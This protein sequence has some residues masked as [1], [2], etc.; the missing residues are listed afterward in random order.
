MQEQL[1]LQ[2]VP[3]LGVRPVHPLQAAEGLQKLSLS[4]LILL[5]AANYTVVGLLWYFAYFV[6][7]YIGILAFLLAI[8]IFL[9][10]KKEAFWFCVFFIII[11][12]PGFFFYNT[13]PL[14]SLGEHMSFD[15]RDLFAMAF[16]AKG[17]FKRAS[18]PSAL[19]NPVLALL[20]YVAF[21]FLLSW[22][23]LPFALGPALNFLRPYFY[24]TLIL[25]FPLVFKDPHEITRILYLIMSWTFFV[26]ATQ[27]YCWKT[28]G[29]L[30]NHFLPGSRVA[31][32]FLADLSVRPIPG[33]H[34]ILIFSYML[35]LALLMGEKREIPRAF[36]WV[37]LGQC[38]FSVLLSG[39]RSW[40]FLLTFV[41]LTAALKGAR[42]VR[43]L[44]AFCL[45][46]LLAVWGMGGFGSTSFG[47]FGVALKRVG[48]LK[49]GAEGDFR[50]IDTA[51]E[52]LTARDKLLVTIAE[53]PVFGWGFSTMGIESYNNDL[54]FD[55]TLLLFGVVGFFFFVTFQV[56][57]ILMLLESRK[58]ALQSSAKG[59]G[60][61]FWGLIAGWSGLLLGYLTTQ[62]LFTWYASAISAM[63]LFVAVAEHFGRQP[64]QT[65]IPALPLQKRQPAREATP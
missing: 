18:P 31:A 14:L 10:S 30:V 35:S 64:Q 24:Y 53:E 55:N 23:T 21:S 11:Q 41:L 49:Q 58:A 44:A 26:F 50:K 15:P 9:A 16:L 52:R 54:G 36:L 12:S 59:T 51:A 46:G 22:M 48:E 32:F 8:G 25:A 45:I 38:F 60:A 40:S 7:S 6:P 42:F 33:G 28:G 34:L 56:R 20:A 13:L 65:G 61:L 62:D 3:G 29:D 57:V 47:G 63:C 43:G 17:F 1:A 19:K 5:P 4:E 37:V 39:T 27:L 2:Q